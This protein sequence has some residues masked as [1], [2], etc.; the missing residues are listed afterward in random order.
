MKWEEWRQAEPVVHDLDWSSVPDHELSLA[1]RCAIDSSIRTLLELPSSGDDV[2]VSARYGSARA[3]NLVATGTRRRRSGHR[4]L[5]AAAC[6]FIALG[7]A[8]GL[9]ASRQH[10]PLPLLSTSSPPVV[11]VSPGPGVPSTAPTFATSPP[12]PVS[13]DALRS[14]RSRAQLEAESVSLLPN[15]PH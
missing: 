1:E 7:V 13:S 12:S 11:T 3:P 5:S 10:V 4:V 15:G 6:G 2:V 9:F 8:A 14:P